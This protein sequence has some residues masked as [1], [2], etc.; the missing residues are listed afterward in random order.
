M[1]SATRFYVC[2]SL[3]DPEVGVEVDGKLSKY[4]FVTVKSG[5]GDW[6][7]PIALTPD[8]ML[9]IAEFLIEQAEERMSK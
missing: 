9:D 4:L 3:G 2:E 6:S 7:N 8:A 1:N 5:H